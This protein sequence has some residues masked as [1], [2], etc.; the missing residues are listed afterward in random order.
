MSEE[1]TQEWY[2]GDDEERFR[3]GPYH[4]KEEA[5]AAAPAELDLEPGQAFYVGQRGVY[6]ASIDS[7]DIIEALAEQANDA[8]GDASEDWLSCVSREARDELD[9]KLAQVLDA[10][11][12]KHGLLPEFFPVE[13]VEQHCAPGLDEDAA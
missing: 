2:I 5:I 8:V 11:L 10:W 7:H 12:A 3:Y 6:T 1:T 13:C 4:S 9:E